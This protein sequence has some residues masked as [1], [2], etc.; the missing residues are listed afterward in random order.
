[1]EIAIEQ[2]LQKIGL[3]TM[4]MELNAAQ[5]QEKIKVLEDTISE[6]QGKKAE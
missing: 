4:L 2:L 3:L 5:A 6:L 1:M